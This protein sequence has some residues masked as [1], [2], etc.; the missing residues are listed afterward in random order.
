[1]ANQLPSWTVASVVLGVVALGTAA[2]ARGRAGRRAGKAL[3]ACW[4]LSWSALAL[5]S[6]L[7]T[8]S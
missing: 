3:L 2:L 5:L 6:V 8:T 1:M 4:S 7:N